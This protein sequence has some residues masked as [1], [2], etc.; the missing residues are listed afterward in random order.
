MTRLKRKKELGSEHGNDVRFGTPKTVAE[1]R[2]KRIAAY[3]PDLIIEVGAGA[4]FQTSA[5]ARIAPVIA[6]DIDGERLGR[7]VLPAE[8]TPIIGDALDKEVIAK[9]YAII[10]AR[11]AKRI[12]IFLDPERPAASRERTLEEIRPD[13]G[14]FLEKYT[15]LSPAIGIEFPPFL[16]L[17]I[18]ISGLPY[19]REY[20][21]I[22]GV[23]N[24]LTCWFGPLTQCEESV[25]A[26]P[27][28]ARIAH[29]G[30]IPLL[31]SPHG[32]A[33]HVLLQ[34]DAALVHSGL[35]PAALRD[36]GIAGVVQQDGPRQIV[37]T[38]R[39]PESPWWRTRKILA[40]GAVEVQR[41]LVKA[42]SVVI[43]GKMS[44]EEQRSRL[45]D[46]SRHCRGTKRMH[47]WIG[48]TWYLTD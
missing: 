34:P 14:E 2:A 48:P 43:H 46:L 19:E 9:I 30:P 47:V 37:L 12:A 36:A 13:I 27:N 15:A 7:A 33:H 5:F 23:L 11:G 17:P 40:S 44:E 45:R 4:G 1:D 16:V 24:R 20:T 35:L 8:V 25:V 28:G 3:R 18:H 22:D 29:N 26:L 10:D 39:A 41:G 31:A 38:S 6:I 32:A 21:S 42:G